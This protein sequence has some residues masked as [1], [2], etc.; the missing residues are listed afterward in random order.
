MR[1]NLLEHNIQLVYENTKTLLA[2]NLTK[3]TSQEELKDFTSRINL[4][5]L[6]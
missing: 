1:E 4:V 2:D 6:N 5:N 3:A